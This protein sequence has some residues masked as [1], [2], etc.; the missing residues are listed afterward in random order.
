MQ[1]RTP[2]RSIQSIPEGSPVCAEEVT[3]KSPS[4]LHSTTT[5]TTTTPN[6]FNSSGDHSRPAGPE[7]RQDSL[8]NAPHLV[9]SHNSHRTNVH[10]ENRSEWSCLETSPGGGAVYHSSGGPDYISD[11]ISGQPQQTSAQVPP[12][13]SAALKLLVSNNVAGSIIGRAGATICEL[14]NQSE[15]RIKLSQTGD[16]YPGTQDRVC[17]VQGEPDRCKMALRLLLERMH[18]LQEHQYSQQMA[19]QMQ[20]QKDVPP[21]FDFVVRLLVPATCCGMIIGKSGSHIKFLEETTGVCSVR[22]SPKDAGDGYPVSAMM[23]QTSERI[24]TITGPNVDSCLQCVYLILQGMVAHSDICR[25]ANMTTSYS[26]ASPDSFFPGA[27]QPM[28]ISLPP[29][30]SRMP[31]QQISWDPS[32]AAH[33]FSPSLAGLR[34]RIASSPDLSP[35][36]QS[37]RLGGIATEHQI[38]DRPIAYSEYNEGRIPTVSSFSSLHSAGP[39]MSGSGMH[40]LYLIPQANGHMDHHP[41]LPSHVAQSMSSPDLLALQLDHS[42]SFGSHQSQ[43]HA[44]RRYPETFVAHPPTMDAP[45]SFNAH[46]LIPDSMIGSILGRRGRT[47]TELESITGTRIR[48]SQRGEFMPGTRSRIVSIRG[49]TA[50]SVM[51]AQFMISQR[52]VLPPTATFMNPDTDQHSTGPPP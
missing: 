44:A 23:M 5:G 41:S 40:P 17:L 15:T 27:R 14:Q 32:P 9:P 4:P 49:A 13:Y 43:G 37:Q 35:A 1:D 26:R 2:P 16:Y 3:S 29:S 42:L 12:S 38:S 50:Q 52:V 33:P 51:Q 34:R 6:S 20:R 36:V 24:T 46:V 10:D 21:A 25:Y 45:G 22:L 39:P 19:W 30:P 47:L 8:T 18:T 7:F 31:Q 28:L 48:A 11:T